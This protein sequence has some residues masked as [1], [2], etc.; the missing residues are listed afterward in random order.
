MNTIDPQSFLEQL[1]ISKVR[2]KAIDYFFTH[3][4]ESIHLRAAVRE[5]DE[6]INA[7]RREL[8]RM[9]EIG[10]VVAENKGNKK[11]FHLNRDFVFFDELLG[12]VF[13]ST[14][15]GSEIIKQQNELGNVRFA[16]LTQGFTHGKPTGNHAVDLF[17]V[18]ENVDLNAVKKIVDE[19]ERRLSR[20][21]NYTILT[22]S[23]FEVR[24]RRK[25]SFVT[26]LVNQHLL[27]L[28]GSG[29]EFYQS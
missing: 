11:F 18:G 3:A 10:L 2:I 21:I 9:E 26:E 27:M 4:N 22:P 14:G 6:E 28:I 1:F 17:I 8:S 25:D 16:V 20:D 19:E 12:F 29:G 24:K 15:L 7:V 5:L 13:K 23:D